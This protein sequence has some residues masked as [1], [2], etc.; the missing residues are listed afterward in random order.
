MNLEK[1]ELLPNDSKKITLKTSV[2]LIQRS[3]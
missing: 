3:N 1:Q 2:Q